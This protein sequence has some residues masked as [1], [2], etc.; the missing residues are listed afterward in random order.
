MFALKNVIKVLRCI[1]VGDS[2]RRLK[3][4]ASNAPNVASLSDSPCCKNEL[5]I[6]TRVAPS[7]FIAK[8]SNLARLDAQLLLPEVI[9]KR[10]FCMSS[11]APDKT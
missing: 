3:F 9:C 2:P 1:I 8:E 10:I 4:I 7:P 11:E 6:D 5:Y